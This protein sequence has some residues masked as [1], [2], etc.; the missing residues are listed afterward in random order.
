MYL[1][2]KKYNKKPETAIML[3][4]V[5]FFAILFLILCNNNPLSYNPYNLITLDASYMVIFLAIFLSNPFEESYNQKVIIEPLQCA[6]LYHNH[7][8][9]F[10]LV[11]KISFT[12]Y[13]NK[14]TKN[15]LEFAR[16]FH[17]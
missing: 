9:G 13:K 14:A 4:N 17:K 3:F 8:H 7:G 5:D 12:S 15:R 11:L 6:F 2:W 16:D 1:S 10:Y